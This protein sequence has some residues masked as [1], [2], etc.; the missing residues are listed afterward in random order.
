MAAA[1]LAAIAGGFWLSRER[2][3]RDRA[4]Q[5]AVLRAEL[6]SMR[7]AI[8]RYTAQHGRPPRSLGEAMANVPVD[9]VTRSAT[10]WKFETEEHAALDDFAKSATPAGPGGIVDVRSG[11]AGHDSHGRPWTDY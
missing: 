11:A 8:K 2:V 7:G 9:P 5:E 10:T 1:I 3:D 6:A 4:R